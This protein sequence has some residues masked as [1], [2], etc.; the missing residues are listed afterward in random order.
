MISKDYR[1]GFM[2]GEA[3]I[4]RYSPGFISYDTDKKILYAF[5][6]KNLSEHVSVTIQDNIV[7]IKDHSTPDREDL[8][9]NINNFEDPQ[10]PIAYNYSQYEFPETFLQG[11]YIGSI[12]EAEKVIFIHYEEDSFINTLSRLE[13][14]IDS[15]LPWDILITSGLV[16]YLEVL[17]EPFVE[18]IP[19]Y[20]GED[21]IQH[22][23]LNY[24]A[25]DGYTISDLN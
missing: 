4:T 24:P 16:S 14:K 22:I 9:Q 2:E 13:N 10:D 19:D 11:N 12:L 17:I 5:S 3:L 18:E 1:M 15:S 6:N 23:M 7:E 25:V 8:T 21:L 20:D